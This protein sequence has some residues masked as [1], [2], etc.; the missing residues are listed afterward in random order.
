MFVILLK[1]LKPIEVVDAH[2]VEHREH[3]K[4]HYEN[5]DLVCSGP[6]NPRMGGVIVS[7]HSS[8]DSV[9][10]MMQADPFTLHGVASYEIVEFSPTRFQAPSPLPV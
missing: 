5:G 10:K 6:Q 1:Y 3:L 7:N 4:R 8:K 9:V 2:L